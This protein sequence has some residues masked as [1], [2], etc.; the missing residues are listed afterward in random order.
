M[1]KQVRKTIEKNYYDP[2]FGG[3]NLDAVFRDAEG[4]MQQAQS[5]GQTFGIIAQAITALNDSHTFFV[6]PSRV[7]QVT[8]GWRMAMVGDR[9]LVTGVRPGKDAEQKGLRV[10]DEILT[11]EGYRPTRENLWK[12]KLSFYSLQP[13]PSLR[14]SV[15]KPD[16][17]QREIETVASVKTRKKTMDLVGSG[18]QFDYYEIIRES[19]SE[20]R[21][22]PHKTYTVGKELYVYRMPDFSLDATEVDSVMGKARKFDAMI[23]DLRGNGGGAVSTLERVAAHLIGRDIV[24]AERKG[25]KK[26]KPITSAGPANPFAGKL[27]V[28]VDSETGSAAEI[29]ARAVQIEKRGAVI[30]DRTAGAVRQSREYDLQIGTQRAV[31]FG[32]SV[33]NADLTMKDGK[34]LEHTGAIPDE[35]AL[36][37]PAGMAAGDDAVLA[38]AA[39]KLGVKLSAAEAGKLFPKGWMD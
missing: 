12:M 31:L 29:L 22:D 17:S 14:L 11:I 7:A 5:A 8:Y 33:T 19:Q 6:P 35:V 2:A 13:R 26:D 27:V 37:S 39:E 1:L 15:R 21:L 4:S 28:L 23:L 16:G 38:R 25:R 10:G 20:A 9:C 3:V 30:G 34:S 18:A 24:L 36:N 32:V